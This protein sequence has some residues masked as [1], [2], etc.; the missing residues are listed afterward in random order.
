MICD[1]IICLLLFLLKD[2]RSPCMRDR[3]WTMLA[4]VTKVS[5]DFGPDC[6]LQEH[7]ADVQD[8]IEVAA[9][10]MKIEERLVA[11]ES[12]WSSAVLGFSFVREDCSPAPPDASSGTSMDTS[13]LAKLVHVPQTLMDDLDEHMLALQASADF[14]VSHLA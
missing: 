3:H 5:V 8:V 7:V 4:A 12:Y 2:I 11:V 9:K 14:L 1:P 13:K 6:R 10:E